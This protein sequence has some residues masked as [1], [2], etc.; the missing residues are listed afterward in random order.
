MRLLAR[1]KFLRG[2]ALDPLRPQRGRRT[3]RALIGEY[4][5]LVDELLRADASNHALA[6]QLAHLPGQ[7]RASAMSG[8]RHLAAARERWA[9]LLAQWRAQASANHP[10]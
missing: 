2:T 1:L 10:A 8:E 9:E 6:L 3:E 7:I 5:E 4:L